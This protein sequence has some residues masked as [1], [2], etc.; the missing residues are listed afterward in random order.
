MII[1]VYGELSCKAFLEVVT[2][3]DGS[4]TLIGIFRAGKVSGATA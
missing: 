2:C 3:E 4:I 1:A